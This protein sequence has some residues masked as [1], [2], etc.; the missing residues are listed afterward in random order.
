[1]LPATVTAVMDAL[2]ALPDAIEYARPAQVVEALDEIAALGVADDARMVR[3][4]LAGPA[5]RADWK[6]K[7]AYGLI[8]CN[9]LIFTEHNGI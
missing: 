9:H 1:M 2:S 7:G 3:E 4:W 5:S 8:Y 6:I